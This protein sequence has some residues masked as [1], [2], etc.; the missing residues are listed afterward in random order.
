VSVR[1]RC[2]CREGAAGQ[3]RRIIRGGGQGRRKRA[4][5]L[6]V[7]F[8]RRQ[9]R[10][11]RRLER[12]VETNLRPPAAAH[13]YIHRR[14]HAHPPSQSAT[15]SAPTLPR[16]QVWKLR[17]RVWVRASQSIHTDVFRLLMLTRR[18]AYPV[19]LS[20]IWASSEGAACTRYT[21]CGAEE[22]WWSSGMA[23]GTHSRVAVRWQSD[24]GW[25][26]I[27]PAPQ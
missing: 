2:A 14:T 21:L 7:A 16:A 8:D 9:R 22:C 25:Q 24:A 1:L 13:T 19:P 20:L 4:A 18:G 10:E 15:H 17:V 26:I 11:L 12:I 6:E 5:H 23:L 27:Q 3:R